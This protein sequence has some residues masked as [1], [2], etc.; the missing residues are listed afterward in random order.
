MQFEKRKFGAVRP[1][2]GARGDARE[3]AFFRLDTDRLASLMSEMRLVA[4]R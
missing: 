3:T 2:G 1:S 4:Q